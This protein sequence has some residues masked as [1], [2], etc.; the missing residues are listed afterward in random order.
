MEERKLGVKRASQ[1]LRINWNVVE[2]AYGETTPAVGGGSDGERRKPIGDDAAGNWNETERGSA[3]CAGWLAFS[4]VPRA[5]L[6]F[7]RPN[8]FF[9]SRG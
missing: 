4:H 9:H 5:W 7:R 6:Y 3:R 1:Q 2:D 8:D